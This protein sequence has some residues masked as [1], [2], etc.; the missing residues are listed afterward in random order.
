MVAS[1]A[2]NL[3]IKKALR[4]QLGSIYKYGF[5]IFSREVIGETDTKRFVDNCQLNQSIT[6]LS[7]D[8]RN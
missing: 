5:I 7:R 2:I 4:I 6:V 1:H 8:L 3:F